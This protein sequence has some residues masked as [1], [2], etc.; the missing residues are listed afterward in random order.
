MTFDAISAGMAIFLDA[1]VLL[2]YFTANPLY[3]GAC[4]K[5]LDLIDN[6]VIRGLTSAH[7]LAELVHRVM[8]IEA[9]QRFGWPSKGIARRLRKN[10]SHVQQLDKARQAVDEITMIGLD[11]L[12]VG[13]ADVSRAIDVTRQFGQLSSDALIVAI[14][15]A[16]GLT[17]LA[18]LD[19]DFDRVPGMTRYAPA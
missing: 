16:N 11:V 5:L 10:P 7:V 4:K 6:K 9:C 3:G 1:N 14:M 18:S 12:P 13:K 17:N 8:T 15:Q 19:A 2:Y